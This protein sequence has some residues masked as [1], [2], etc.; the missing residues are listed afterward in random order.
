MTINIIFLTITLLL[1]IYSIKL[2]K[3]LVVPK[4]YLSTSNEVK[5]EE[6]GGIKENF[7]KNEHYFLSNYENTLEKIE[8]EVKIGK[9]KSRIKNRK[10]KLKIPLKNKVI[11]KIGKPIG[12]KGGGRKRPTRIDRKLSISLQKCPKCGESFQGRRPHSSYK[13]YLTDMTYLK[14]GPQIENT[15]YEIIGHECHHCGKVRFPRVDAP[16]KGRFGYGMIT[17]VLTKRVCYKMPYDSIIKELLEFYGEMITR[18][19]LI[20]WIKYTIKP[21]EKLYKKLWKKAMKSNYLHV[22]E[23]G[24]PLKG[25]NWWMWVLTTKSITLYHI[26]QSRGHEA[27]EEEIEEFQGVIIADFWSA[28]NKLDKDQQKCWA[29]LIRELKE[30]LYEKNHEKEQLQQKLQKDTE[31]KEELENE[32]HNSPKK[33][34][35]KRK[36]PNPLITSEIKKIQGRISHLNK[37][38][39]QFLVILNFFTTFLHRYNEA[40][41][42]YSKS[43]G[44]WKNFLPSCQEAEQMLEDLIS[45]IEKAHISDPDLTRILNR[46]KKFKSSLFVFLEYDD[47]DSNNSLAER[48]IRHFVTQR[49]ISGGFGSEEVINAYAINLSI[50]QTCKLNKVDYRTALNL[51]FHE[52]WKEVLV[53]IPDT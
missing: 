47:V 32:G 11:K 19:T 30:I 53:L 37:V 31:V 8:E 10:K 41:E 33:R 50:A 20:N 6:S 28:Y 16:P 21:L 35:R 36:L 24:L 27:I 22:D 1:I 34:G 2:I 3:E 23:T 45:I 15:E 9:Y 43:E 17:Y 40:K 29:H 25:K 42:N 51:C 5:L 46:L 44:D 48:Q 7:D 26:N 39:W 49:K 14:R 52:R 38:L 13:R 18:T 12:A 4:E